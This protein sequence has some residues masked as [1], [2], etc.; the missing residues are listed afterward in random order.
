MQL[1]DTE[2]EHEDK[3]GEE[4]EKALGVLPEPTPVLPQPGS[5]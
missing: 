4:R 5:R 3:R 2:E 1:E